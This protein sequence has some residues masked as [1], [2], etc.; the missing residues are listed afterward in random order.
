M[1]KAECI[2]T[3]LERKEHNPDLS[4]DE[5]AMGLPGNITQGTFSKW[6]ARKEAI[7]SEAADSYKRRLLKCR[8]SRL[9]YADVEAVLMEKFKRQRAEARRV[10]ARWL[11]KNAVSIARDL[12]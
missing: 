12:S 4:Q 9:K 5:F 11:K 6:L 7:F 10:S 2:E 3:Y 8:P 1:H